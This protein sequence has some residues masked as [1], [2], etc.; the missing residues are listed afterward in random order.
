MR[1][2]I[3]R[4]IVRV[5]KKGGIRGN[6]EDALKFPSAAIWRFRTRETGFGRTP[7]IPICTIGNPFFEDFT[8]PIE[9]PATKVHGLISVIRKI[10]Q[11]SLNAYFRNKLSTT[12]RSR[13]RGTK[14]AEFFSWEAVVFISS[15]RKSKG[16]KKWLGPG[17][18]ISEFWE[19]STL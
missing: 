2:A 9:A 19:I 5:V 3:K 12:L 16:G 6:D 15:N 4:Q 8:N 11:A 10:R 7:K 17:I 1:S 18:I 14:S 13:V